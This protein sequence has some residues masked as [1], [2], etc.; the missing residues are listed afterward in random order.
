[1]CQMKYKDIVARQ[2]HAYNYNSL[3]E[4]AEVIT[5]Q[6]Y[7]NEKYPEVFPWLVF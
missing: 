6:K 1:M 5:L 3:F 7:S 2:R 4:E